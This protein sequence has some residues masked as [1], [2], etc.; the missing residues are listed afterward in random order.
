MN[1]VRI[2]D[3]TRALHNI[4]EFIMSQQTY[5][6]AYLNALVNRIGMVLVTSKMWSNPWAVFKRG[7]LDF[8]E[9][10][11]EIF[12]NIAKPHKFN[13]A[14]AETEVF[15][16]EIPDVRA[17]FHTMNYQ[18]FY[19]Q[20]IKNVQLRQA[21]LAYSGI[22]DLIARIVDAMSTS[23]ELDEFLVM[24][25]MMCRE[26]L[27][28][29]MYTVT[30]KPITGANADPED[31]V[32][33]YREYTNNLTFLKTIYNR[34]RVRNATPVADQVIIVPNAL[35]AVVGVKVL[36]NAFHIDEVQY[37]GQRIAI[38]SFTFD[39]DDTERL[40][41]LFEEDDTYT[42]FTEAEIAKLEAVTAI[43]VDR[44]WWMVFDN[45]TSFTEN[46]NG[47]GLYW[48]YWYHVWKTF[49]VS[50]YAN[51]IVF[52]TQ[53]NAITGVTVTPSTASVSQGASFGLTAAVAGTGL[54]DQTVTW[55]IE[56]QVSSNTRI[57]PQSGVLHIGANEPTTEGEGE[58]STAHTITV[59]A[60]A[61]D[62]TA[63]TATITVVSA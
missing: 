7:T 18:K 11:E 25:Y 60:T 51:A 10:I 62:G 16:R 39:A 53:A 52:N 40:S 43:K 59:T 58:E 30:T 33:K 44:E 50:P 45:F 21:F 47:E 42:P 23:M 55:S 15:K 9:T 17:A 63:G 48:Q 57:D 28:G 41:E 26:I 38:D 61:V 2:V 8:G 31:A 36:A 22:S 14:K 19:K 27:N 5:Q 29:G 34:A 6:N 56:G 35:E 32:T 1:P 46:Y 20:T 54:I 13:P 24:K 12:V 4:G 3:D 37:L 49:S